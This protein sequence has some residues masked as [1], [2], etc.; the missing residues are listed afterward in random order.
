LVVEPDLAFMAST[1][2]TFVYNH[3]AATLALVEAFALTG[4][5]DLWHSAQRALSFVEVARNPYLV[6]SYGV[7]PGDNNSS[8][9]AWMSLAL[10]TACAVNAAWR[11]DANPPPFLLDGKVREGLRWWTSK[12]RDDE[13]GRIGYCNRGGWPSRLYEVWRQFP[14]EAGE[15][16]TAA[17]AFVPILLHSDERESAFATAEEQA[18]QEKSVR[19]CAGKAPRWAAGTVD[20]PYWHFGSLLLWEAGGPAWKSWSAALVPATLDAQR[21]DGKPSDLKGSWD[22]VG[23]WGRAGGRV[24]STAIQALTVL[25][26]VRF[27]NLPR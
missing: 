11:R 27:P 8:V 5:A 9:T 19:L 20:M 23:A 3:A 14:L 15:G 12:M 2:S 21:Q 4:D 26:P 7:K 22:P 13:T 17:L 6:W 1:R 25:T 10:G 16:L 24:Y 18:L